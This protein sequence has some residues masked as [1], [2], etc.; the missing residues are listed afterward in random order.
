MVIG[1]YHSHPNQDS[2]PSPRDAAAAAEEGTLWLIIG[3]S[4]ARLWRVVEG[5]PWLDRFEPVAL[6]VAAPCAGSS[7]SP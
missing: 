2:T 7:A 4:T 6:H 1:H 3:N 5:G